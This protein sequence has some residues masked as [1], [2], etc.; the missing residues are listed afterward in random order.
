MNWI[1]LVCLMLGAC[2]GFLFAGLFHSSPRDDD[3]RNR[4]R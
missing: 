3:E 4:Y 1:D 2:I